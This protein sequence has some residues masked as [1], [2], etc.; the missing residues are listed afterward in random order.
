MKD[1]NR[2]KWDRTA[3]A[4]RKLNYNYRPNAS[5]IFFETN[6]FQAENVTV[7]TFTASEKLAVNFFKPVVN[8]TNTA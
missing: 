4:R 5:R 1:I 6:L 2:T 7:R 8:R 3:F